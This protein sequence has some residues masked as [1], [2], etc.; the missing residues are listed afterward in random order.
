MDRRVEGS[1]NET[2]G[3]VH[4]RENDK[5]ERERLHAC[6]RDREYGGRW[7]GWGRGGESEQRRK[8]KGVVWGGGIEGEG[9]RRV[10]GEIHCEEQDVW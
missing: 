9:G 3:R 6:A 4:V 10:G 2:D 5:E 1:V 7:G 8:R